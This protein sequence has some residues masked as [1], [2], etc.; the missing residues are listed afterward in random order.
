MLR[1]TDR[2]DRCGAQAYVEVM[3]NAVPLLF[4]A[5]DFAKHAEYIVMSGYVV[6]VDEREKLLN[7][8]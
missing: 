5:H 3:V 2:C 1:A 7:R 6:A 8:Y 4:C